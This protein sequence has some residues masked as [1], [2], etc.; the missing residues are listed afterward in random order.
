[1]NLRLQL[2]LLLLI[3]F[4][5]SVYAQYACTGNQN[6]AG[7]PPCYYNQSTPTFHGTTADG[8]R[9]VNVFIQ[10]GTG[11]DSWDVPP[12]SG[13]TNT[14]IWSAVETGRAMWNNATDSTSN[15]GTTNRPPYFFEQAQAGGTS[16]ADVIIVR[17]TSVSFASTNVNTAPPQLFA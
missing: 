11:A 1:M 2:A 7:C 8:R 9:K 6:T 5:S 14:Q 4:A 3:A 16:N 12:V 17:D 15:P 13:N 10:G